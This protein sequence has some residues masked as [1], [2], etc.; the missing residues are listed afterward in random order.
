[1][2]RVW[3]VSFTPWW[4]QGCVADTGGGRRGRGDRGRWH[5][6]RPSP[7][8]LQGVTQDQLATLFDNTGLPMNNS[9]NNITLSHVTGHHKNNSE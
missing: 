6:S 3:S 5:S 2:V 1:M 7:G 8:R 4:S 9:Q